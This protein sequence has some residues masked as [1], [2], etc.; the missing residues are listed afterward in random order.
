MLRHSFATR[1][2]RD[3]RRLL[4]DVQ[5]CGLYSGPRPAG[6]GSYTV[7]P[8][9]VS[10]TFVGE[11]PEVY[12]ERD[13][14]RPRRL[15]V[16]RWAHEGDWMKGLFDLNSADDLCRKLEAD[17][18]RVSENPGD[19]FAAFD[20]VVTAWHLWSGASLG[21]RSKLS[22]MRF[23]RAIRFCGSASILPWVQSISS[24]RIPNSNLSKT[25]TATAHGNRRLGLPESGPQE[26]GRRSSRCTWTGLHK[27]NLVNE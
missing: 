14:A 21:S 16:A 8:K 20:F 25:R 15:I 6:E 23:A 13:A 11:R 17:Y 1:S 27:P 4:L 12:A 26:C 2:R 22:G 3:T 10:L 9:D 18:H 7:R 19:R 24:P 5:I